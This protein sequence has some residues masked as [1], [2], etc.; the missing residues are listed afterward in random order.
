[1]PDHPYNSYITVNLLKYDTSWLSAF[2]FRKLVLVII[3]NPLTHYYFQMPSPD[4]RRKQLVSKKIAFVKPF[5]PI[6]PMN[7]TSTTHSVPLTIVAGG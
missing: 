3:A 2:M 7:R 1:M 5:L 6:A 4:R